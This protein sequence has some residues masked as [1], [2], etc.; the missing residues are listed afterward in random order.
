MLNASA[1]QRLHGPEDLLGKIPYLL[2]F[3]PSDSIVTLYL[4]PEGRVL[5]TSAIAIDAPTQVIVDDQ[6]DAANRSNAAM[7]AVV[8]YGP[9]TASGSV[10][11]VA[12]AM[13]RHVQVF[14]T[15]IV[16]GGYFYCL[17]SG[18]A[19]AAV[20]GMPFDPKASTIAAHSTVLGEVALPSRDALLALAAPDPVAQAAVQ[21][22]LPRART[23]HLPEL[24]ELDELL[25]RAMLDQRLTDDEVARLA[26]LLRRPQVRDAAWQQTDQLMW[27]RNLWLDVT[28]RVPEQYV[29]A[30]ASLAA[31]CAWRRGESI[32]AMAA[33]RRAAAV[34]PSNTITR[35]VVGAIQSRIRP[36]ELI[37]VWPL[38]P[39]SP[40]VTDPR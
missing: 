7:I 20:T 5:A 26:L 21:A 8:G 1:P 4:G 15:Y 11:A 9:L 22:A 13:N 33:A 19:C 16:S 25:E 36:T 6:L 35:V 28:R 40:T 32:L 34:D 23:I 14:S 27:Q 30:P 24:V 39:T 17:N 31:W 29:T 10:T 12:D 18:C 2:E 37:P 3:H 38:P